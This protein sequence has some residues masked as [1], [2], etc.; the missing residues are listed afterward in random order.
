M[1]HHTR[2]LSKGGKDQIILQD[3]RHRL[4]KKS[5]ARIISNGKRSNI[6]QEQ[7][8]ESIIVVVDKQPTTFAHI[9]EVLSLLLQNITTTPLNLT[10]LLFFSLSLFC[11]DPQK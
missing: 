3:Q 4:F 6:Q 2:Y 1:L 10:S 11:F 5:K 8:I 9:I 7:D